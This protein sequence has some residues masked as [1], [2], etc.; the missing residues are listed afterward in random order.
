MALLA[1]LALVA[2]LALRA[3]TARLEQ[4]VLPELPAYKA[5]Q[6]R[7]GLRATLVKR[8]PLGRQVLLA[9]AALQAHPVM[10]A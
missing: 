10:T 5:L 7:K 4:R 2:Q 8:D 1:Q 6:G 3:M 9:Q